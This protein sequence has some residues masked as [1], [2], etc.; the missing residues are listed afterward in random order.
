MALSASITKTCTTPCR[1]LSGTMNYEAGGAVNRSVDI[2]A[3]SVDFPV[4]FGYSAVQQVML[5]MLAKEGEIT[6]AA[7]PP[8]NPLNTLTLKAG[9]PYTWEQ[10]GYVESYFQNDCT[11]LLVT[12]ANSFP[13]HLDIESLTNPTA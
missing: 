10:D 2:P 8:G 6:I 3:E 11:Q 4:A 9:V 12:N 13:V 1:I 7:N 5:Y